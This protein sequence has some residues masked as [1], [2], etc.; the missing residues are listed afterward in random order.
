MIELEEKMG[1]YCQTPIKGGVENE[2]GKVNILLQTYI[3]KGNIESFSLI[4]DMAYV[5]QVRFIYFVYV[6]VMTMVL[7]TIL[8]ELLLIQLFWINRK[9]H[10]TL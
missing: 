7:I 5:A 4:S 10:R 2:Y 3:S 1:E 6:Y 9:M 8:K